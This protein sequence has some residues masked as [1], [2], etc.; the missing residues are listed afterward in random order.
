MNLL[1][2]P[3]FRSAFVGYLEWG[4][5]IAV[6]NSNETEL[7]MNEEQPMPSWGMGRTGRPLYSLTAYP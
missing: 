4:T 1:D 5:R 7:K 2:D 3:E 6:V